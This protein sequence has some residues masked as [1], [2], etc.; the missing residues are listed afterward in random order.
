MRCER[1]I[2]LTLVALGAWIAWAFPCRGQV[3]TASLTGVVTDPSGG[4]IVEAS[5]QLTSTATG[6]QRRTRTSA[7]G[8]YA[9]SQILPGS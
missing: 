8:R 2:W 4:A 3:F 7:D 5:V 6:E 1:A 9:F